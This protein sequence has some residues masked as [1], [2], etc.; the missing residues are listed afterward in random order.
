MAGQQYLTAAQLAERWQCSARHV[1]RLAESQKLRGMRVGDLW[2]F[3]VAAVEAYEQA[4]TSEPADLPV[5]MAARERQEV[6]APGSLDSVA[7]PAGYEPV[8]PELWPGYVPQTKKK[9][10]LPL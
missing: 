7:L 1:R 2:R 3:S 5:A 10:A 9:A 8:F 6:R 4:Q